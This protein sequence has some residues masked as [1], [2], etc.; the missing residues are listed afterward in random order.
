MNQIKIGDFIA[1]CRK[2]LGL[3]QFQL[4]EKL[5]ITDRAVSKWEN[6]KSLPDASIM[7]ELCDILGISVN[8]LLRGEKEMVENKRNDDLIIDLVKEKEFA[9]KM[10]LKIEVFLGVL[11]SVIF[12]SLVL[13]AGLVELETYL[14]IILILVGLVI[15]M[16]GV[17]ICIRLE[18][19]AGYYECKKCGHKY[20]PSYKAVYMA[21][22]YFR[23]RLMKCPNCNKISYQRKVIKK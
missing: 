10:L 8:D 7:L 21:P 19:K 12:F 14:R 4:A 6:G 22:H 9:D 16:I 3:T 13:V 11:V 15:F 17:S 23:N 5:G 18:Q 2:D 20:I 1:K